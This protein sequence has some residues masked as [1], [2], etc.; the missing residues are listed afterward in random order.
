MGSRVAGVPLKIPAIETTDY[1]DYTDK[2]AKSVDIC[3]ICED[4]MRGVS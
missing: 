2:S 3:V 1:T 4:E